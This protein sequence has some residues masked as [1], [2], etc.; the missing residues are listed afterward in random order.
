M[1]LKDT[2]LVIATHNTGKLAEIRMALGHV[3]TDIT[4]VAD[5]GLNA[6]VE[7][8]VTYADNALIKARAAARISGRV[9]LADDSGVGITA[10]GDEPGVLTKD[11]ELS[12]PTVDDAY[13]AL[14]QRAGGDTAAI[15]TCVFALAWP[16][17]R[18]HVITGLAHGTLIYPGRGTNGFGFDPYFLTTD[19]RT[20]GELELR[21]KE[22]GSHRGSAMRQLLALVV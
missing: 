13:K 17:G 22:I 14:H 19:G 5:Y 21:Q 16:D 4:G 15:A 7:D 12:F 20:F 11:Y 9:A 8:G 18:E 2:P 10:L 1:L 6:P 3:L